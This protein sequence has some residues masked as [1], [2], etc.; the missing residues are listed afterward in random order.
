MG[1]QHQAAA[2]TG[3]RQCLFGYGWLPHGIENRVRSAACSQLPGRLWQP[4]G[5][6]DSVGSQSFGELPIAVV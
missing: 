1:K 3:Q 5:R 6:A 2:F 4:L